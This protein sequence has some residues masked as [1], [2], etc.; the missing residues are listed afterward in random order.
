MPS[1]SLRPGF[2]ASNLLYFDSVV[3][4][5]DFFRFENG[6]NFLARTCK[7]EDLWETGCNTYAYFIAELAAHSNVSINCNLTAGNITYMGEQNST[8]R[9][10]NVQ[11]WQQCLH[12]YRRNVTSL[13]KYYFTTNK[14]ETPSGEKPMPIRFESRMLSGRKYLRILLFGPSN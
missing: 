11:M 2:F 10:I 1:S 5:C 9:A 6:F 13:S 7:K 14:T 8:V 4:N 3:R 12:D